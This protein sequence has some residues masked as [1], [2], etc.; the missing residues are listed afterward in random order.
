MREFIAAQKNYGLLNPLKQKS[1][2]NDKTLF[3]I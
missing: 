3:R 2:A 1:L